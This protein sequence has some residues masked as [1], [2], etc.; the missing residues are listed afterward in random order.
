MNRGIIGYNPTQRIAPGLTGTVG[1]VQHPYPTTGTVGNVQ[2]PYPNYRP[3]SVYPQPAQPYPT[4]IAYSYP[5]GPQGTFVGGYPGAGY[6]AGYQP[7]RYPIAGAAV[8]GGAQI[9]NPN[10]AALR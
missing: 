3:T 5:Q 6:P 10:A 7:G 4:G 1:N 8:P 9:Y 2:Y